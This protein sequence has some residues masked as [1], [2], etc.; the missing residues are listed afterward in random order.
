MTDMNDEMRTLYEYA[1]N[2]IHFPF[3]RDKDFLEKIVLNMNNIKPFESPDMIL[4]LGDKVLAIEHFEFDASSFNR[5]G[6]MDKRNLAERNRKFDNLI[7]DQSIDEETIFSTTSVECSYSSTYYI[8]NFK[9]VFANHL[10]K[11]EKYKRNLVEKSIV[12]NTDD[13]IICFFIVDTTPLGCYY[14]EDGAP[15]SF[16]LLQVSEFIDIITK[17]NAVDCVLF[18]YFNG[19]KNDLSF[20]SN[21]PE[22]LESIK[23]QNVIDFGVVDFFSFDPQETRFC[24]KLKE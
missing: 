4:T 1:G 6:S 12:K 8:K 2:S 24:T 23:K 19:T 21:Y 15:K 20:I 5:K 17:A 11:I 18:G 3:L 10:S 13:I 16:Y 9:S 14:L 7:E 22:A